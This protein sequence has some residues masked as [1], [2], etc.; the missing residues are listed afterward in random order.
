MERLEQGIR[1]N[2]DRAILD[3]SA[4]A[5][6]FYERRGYRVL[7]REILSIGNAEFTYPIMEK[8]F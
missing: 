7:R 6:S 2:S 8:I 4:P 3:V 5:E 1:K